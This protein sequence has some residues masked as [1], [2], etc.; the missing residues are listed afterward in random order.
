M[1]KKYV[2]YHV[3]I[4]LDSKTR[5]NPLLNVRMKQNEADSEAQDS[6]ILG[7]QYPLDSKIGPNPLLNGKMRL[8]ESWN[9]GI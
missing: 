3:K 9:L 2:T 5:S 1:F 6:W 7:L 8:L 4:P